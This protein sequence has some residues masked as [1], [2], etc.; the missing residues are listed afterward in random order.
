MDIMTGFAIFLI[1]LGIFQKFATGEN[2]L[3]QESQNAKD[4]SLLFLTLKL[5]SDDVYELKKEVDEL[6]SK[7]SKKVNE[8]SDLFKQISE[9]QVEIVQLKS[10]I[11]DNTVENK[12]IASELQA[13]IDDL[14]SEINELESKIS[15]NK[16]NNNELTS[17][18][19]TLK[20]EV[21]GLKDVIAEQDDM[22][23]L[24]ESKLSNYEAQK[25]DGKESGATYVR[26]G[27]TQ[28]PSGK[29]TVKIYEGFAAGNHYRNTGGG[30]ELL[31]LPR[32]P[33]WGKKSSSRIGHAFLYGT[34]YEIHG[35]NSRLLF[36]KEIGGQNAPCVV[37]QS[38]GRLVALR[39][40]GRTNC[41]SG[42]T[43]EYRGYLFSEYH[44]HVRSTDYTCVDSDPEF[45]QGKQSDTDG[46]LLYPVEASCS[47][48]TLPCPPYQ[49]GWE[50]A[51]VICTK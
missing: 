50:I 14:K 25:Q 38:V 30:V 46:R 44:N 27:R 51:C 7:N 35:T 26:W 33:S 32:Q 19:N 24:L 21:S 5:M 8:D 2:S 6:K 1:A 22:I 12:D 49:D 40:P 3:R 47:G 43:E 29:G 45:V 11:G 28:C 18:K 20:V 39:I 15:D 23:K 34:E 16:N 31:C 10:E 48:G 17:E 41:Y 9:L 37:C 42:W 36:N 4:S 13:K